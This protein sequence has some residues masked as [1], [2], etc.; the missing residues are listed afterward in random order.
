[1]RNWRDFWRDFAWCFRLTLRH[2]EHTPLAF[3]TNV[4]IEDRSLAV[5]VVV[6]VVTDAAASVARAGVVRASEEN[7]G[8]MA[9]AVE[10]EEEEVEEEDEDETSAAGVA[11]RMGSPW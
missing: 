6:G 5:E 7:N 2:S 8:L 10:E 9:V 1:M 3:T 4:V 11:R